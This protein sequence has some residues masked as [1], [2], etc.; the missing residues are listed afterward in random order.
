M[1]KYI[2]LTIGPI[3]KTI[4]SAKATRELWGA[5]YIFSYIMKTIIRHFKDKREFIIPY[6]KDNSL[7]QQGQEV[8][9]FHDNFIFEAESGDYEELGKIIKKVLQ[10]LGHEIDKKL[11]ITGTYDYL[12]SYF[13]LYYCEIE[14]SGSYKDVANEISDILG[15][16]ELESKFLPEEEDDKKQNKH[17]N[18]LFSFLYRV[19]RSFLTEDAYLKNHCFPSILEISGEKKTGYLDWSNVQTDDEYE[20]NS[21]TLESLRRNNPGKFKNYHKYIAI[22][23]ADGDNLGEYINSLKNNDE[24]GQL[25]KTLFDFIISAK[26][27]IQ[28]FGGETIYGGGDDLLFFSP[29]KSGNKNV[30]DLVD[31]IGSIFDNLFKDSEHPPTLS[32]GISITY[33]KSPMG[34]SLENA[35]RYLFEKS[36]S[37]DSKNAITFGVEKHSGQTFTSTIGKNSNVYS[38][39]REIISNDSNDN[40]LSSV[41]YKINT[42]K[43]IISTIKTDKDR[44]KNYFDNFY[45]EDIHKGYKPFFNELVN[46]LFYV[47]DI[48]NVTSILRLKKFLEGGN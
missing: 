40:M 25:S 26:T 41:I 18:P 14:N 43:N 28:N 34:E 24:Y 44:L 32:F 4:F 36:K 38:I 19:N 7:F 16:L 48:K 30:F 11:S 35:G 3:N 10:D 12:Q 8:G 6:T 21:N 13:Q 47:K 27:M 23:Q 17:F 15:V 31:D 39:F 9:L 1:A 5:S 46:L 45:N 29:I 2:G 22:I 20:E 33:Y 37:F 42:H